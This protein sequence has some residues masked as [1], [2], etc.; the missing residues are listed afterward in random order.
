[1]YR[2]LLF[3]KYGFAVSLFHDDGRAEPGSWIVV[4]EGHVSFSQA[5]SWTSLR[6]TLTAVILHSH[7]STANA[8]NTVC[9][10][11]SI[12]F[13]STRKNSAAV[14]VSLA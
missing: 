13:S 3:L 6:L 11:P 14:T 2:T 5:C 12:T 1:M 9:M 8:Q 10:I 4:G 7:A